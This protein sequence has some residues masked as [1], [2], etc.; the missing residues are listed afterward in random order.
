LAYPIELPFA[1]DFLQQK[2]GLPEF[3]S[4]RWVTSQPIFLDAFGC[5]RPAF[6]G[7]YAEVGWIV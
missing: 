3:N 5:F 1:F 6:K 7:V 2:P 4:T